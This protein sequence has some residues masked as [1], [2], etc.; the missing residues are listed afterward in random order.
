MPAHHAATHGVGIG[1]ALVGG[2]DLRDA[3]GCHVRRPADSQPVLALREGA[4]RAVRRDRAR[5]TTRSTP[6]RRLVE[7]VHRDVNEPVVVRAR[8][9]RAARAPPCPR[10]Q[11]RAAPSAERPP[12]AWG[13]RAP[14]STR[15][16]ASTSRARAPFRLRPSSPR[17]QER[18]RERECARV[19]RRIASRSPSR[20]TSHR[21]R[22]RF[23]GPPS[24]RVSTAIAES[25]SPS[26][27]ASRPRASVAMAS[28]HFGGIARSSARQYEATS[29]SSPQG[30]VP[31]S[32]QKPSWIF[33]GSPVHGER[34]ADL[35]R[36]GAAH[37]VDGVADGALARAR[38]SRR[39]GCSRAIFELLRR[40]R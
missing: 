4:P 22:P 37:R 16:G 7:L 15:R 10:A 21:P 20:S 3:C 36:D 9:H 19:A 26:S 39:R 35:V 23:A 30:T 25:T 34:R 24:Q 14:T 13:S 1:R 18:R 38:A 27:I 2:D 40:S 8:E 6:S 5:R 29:T 11:S 17:A 33:S 28:N 12:A 31:S 32:Y